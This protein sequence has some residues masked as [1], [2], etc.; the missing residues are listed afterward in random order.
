M[1]NYSVKKISNDFNLTGNFTSDEWNSTDSIKIDL[2]PWH[3]YKLYET[4]EV[5]VKMLYTDNNL[6]IRFHVKENYIFAQKT[7]FQD[8]V[9]EDSCVEFFVSPTESGYFNFE[10]NCIGTI[11]LHF[12]EDR[13]KSVTVTDSDLK[14]IK[15][16]TSLSKGKKINKSVPCP[17]EGYIV[18]YSIPFEIFYKYS[19]AEVPT[20]NSVWH[21]NFYKCGDLSPEP[22]WG[23]WAPVKTPQPDFHQP[24]YFGEIIFK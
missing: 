16:A 21:A 11:H 14:K 1:N 17:K 23:T 9:C 5:N 10:V 13:H 8:Q 15:I 4:P 24:K 7:N 2:W 19:K 3:N 6:Y 22:S 20:N 12:H 18:E